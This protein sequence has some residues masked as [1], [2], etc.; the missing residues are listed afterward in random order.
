MKTFLL[1]IAL[2]GCSHHVFSPPSQ[3][4]GLTGIRPLAQGQRA[5]DVEVSRHAEIFDPA[6]FAG[7]G[8]LRTG[9]GD[10]AEVSVEGTLMQVADTGPST[11]DRSIYAGRAGVRSRPG[12]S[13]F[14]VFA[15]LGGGFAP[16]GGG[17]AAADA[18]IAVGWDNCVLVP[19]LQGSGLISRPLAPRPIDVTTD[20]DHPQTATPRPTYGLDVRAGLRISL[21]PFACRRGEPG[22]WLTGGLDI[23]TLVDAEQSQTLGGVGFGLEIPL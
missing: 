19:M 5:L 14:A 10:N 8:R 12:N 7:A 17:F 6:V 23:T 4:F 11:A 9:I 3:A 22:M 13:P 15:G 18:G 1:A 2:T 21:T 20:L 16:A